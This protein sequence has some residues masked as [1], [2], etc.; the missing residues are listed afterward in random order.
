[1]TSTEINSAILNLWQISRTALAGNSNI[2][3]RYDRMQY[4]KREM[5]ANHYDLLTH[6]GTGK[7]LWLEIE[8]S[9]N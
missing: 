3:S 7:Q 2:P 5:I 9:I 1:M 6:I 4:V 8:S